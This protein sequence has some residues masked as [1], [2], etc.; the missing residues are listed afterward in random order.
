MGTVE[1]IGHF[2]RMPKYHLNLF[3]DIDCPDSEGHDYRD[4][5]AAKAAAI[6]SARGMMAEH[7]IA[8]K[9]VTLHHRIEVA[10]GSGKVLAV[11]P[12]GELLTIIP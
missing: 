2:K 3:N 6:A 11:I 4:L 5:S 9:A 8:G 1:V 7:V 10:D 12:F